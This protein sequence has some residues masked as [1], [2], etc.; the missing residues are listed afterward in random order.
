[1]R[2]VLGGFKNMFKQ[3]HINR[4]RNKEKEEKK[5]KKKKNK[6]ITSL[7]VL[8]IPFAL[9][10]SAIG[11][12]KDKKE[13]TKSTKKEQITKLNTN[14]NDSNFEN[15]NKELKDKEIELIEKEKELDKKEAE[16]EHQEE[17]K[18]KYD[19]IEEKE[20]QEQTSFNEEKKFIEEEIKETRH[21]FDVTKIKEKE[22]L[23]VVHKKERNDKEKEHLS[24]IVLDEQIT[25]TKELEKNYYNHQINIVKKDIKNNK[26]VLKRFDKLPTT[27]ANIEL[28]LRYFLAKIDH[29]RK[30]VQRSIRGRSP[31]SSYINTI[32]ISNALKAMRRVTSGRKQPF[33]TPYFHNKNDLFQN[34]ISICQN[35]IA[36]IN[37]LRSEIISILGPTSPLLIELAAIEMHLNDQILEMQRQ[38]QMSKGRSKTLIS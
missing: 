11:L 32:L 30:N 10:L 25:T 5:E 20:N 28:Y 6:I 8:L 17:I 24:K 34:T 35:S 36:D 2:G 7:Q 33:N 21:I 13:I 9:L 29:I 3:W 12:S 4:K 37:S 23:K 27:S 15:K 16:L 22:K 19:K 1:M 38:E 18:S 26:K 14:Q 31:I